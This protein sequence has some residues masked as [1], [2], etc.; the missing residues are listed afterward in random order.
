MAMNELDLANEI[1]A[2]LDS[3][4]DPI[5]SSEFIESPVANE[6]W[7]A[8]AKAIINH[9]KQNAEVTPGSWSIE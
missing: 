2:E 5:E 8:V 4:I 3:L 7:K 6:T 9:I 1:Q